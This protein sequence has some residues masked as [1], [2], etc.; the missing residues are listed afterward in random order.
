M[1]GVNWLSS[2]VLSNV[3]PFCVAYG[4]DKYMMTQ[5]RGNANSGCWTSDDGINNWTAK[6]SSLCS[7]TRDIIFLNNNFFRFNKTGLVQKSSNLGVTWTTVKP[8]GSA[9]TDCDWASAEGGTVI[10]GAF[11]S[12]SYLISTDGI[13]FYTRRSAVSPM[14]YH[15]GMGNGYA[16]SAQYPSSNYPLK[17]SVSYVL[18]DAPQFASETVGTLGAP[19]YMKVK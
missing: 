18:N 9:F 13:N 3:R 7:D 8:I 1:D 4:S 11:G 15:G 2:S 5:G 14:N 19:L 6:G 12:L 10:A 16:I 17:P